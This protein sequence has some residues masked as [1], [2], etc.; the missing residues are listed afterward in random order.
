M[1]YLENYNSFT[2]KNK[3][4]TLISIHNRML[5]KLNLE[6]SILSV[7]VIP[8]V[9]LY[10]IFKNL[11]P[12]LNTEHLMLIVIYILIN[13]LNINIELSK[14]LSTELSAEIPD[15]EQLVKKFTLSFHTILVITNMVCKKLIGGVKNLLSVENIV[16]L[17][18]LISL[19]VLEQNMMLDD[20]AYLIQDK[21]Q[22][23]LK[24]MVNFVNN[25]I[26]RNKN[27]KEAN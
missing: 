5:K 8:I 13:K 12:E 7:K 15:F 10:K 23:V 2:A 25:N 16:E 17:L 22:K 27:I 4:Y 19:F 20:L 24:N 3:D 26:G 9:E 21:N 18:N 6:S 1:K 11:S 14:L